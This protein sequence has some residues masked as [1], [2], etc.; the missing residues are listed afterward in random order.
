M[1]SPVYILGI[2]AFYHDS[3]AC[4]IKDGDIVVS[5]AGSVG[6]SY[7]ITN[8]EPSVFA[9][10]LIRFKPLIDRKYVYYYLKSRIRIEPIIYFI[11]SKEI[12]KVTDINRK[13]SVQYEKELVER[14]TTT[15]VWFWNKGSNQES[16]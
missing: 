15:R 10:Y 1:N 2:S 7:L 8:P 14:V 3:A 13:I 5:R 12:S 11:N 9:S 16:Q 4:L 6:V